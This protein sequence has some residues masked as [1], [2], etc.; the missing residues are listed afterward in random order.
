CFAGTCA[1]AFKG[2]N[3]LTTSYIYRFIRQRTGIVLADFPGDG[4]ISAIIAL[5][6]VNTAPRVTANASYTYEGEFA[7]LTYAITDPDPYDTVTVDIN[8]RDG[9]TDRVFVPPGGG[10]FSITHRYL[11]D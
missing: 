3:A 11:D 6:R 7:E 1:V 2:L 10:S 9:T 4:L 8:W 5:N